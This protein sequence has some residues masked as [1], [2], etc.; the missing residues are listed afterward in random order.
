VGVGTER[1]RGYAITVV[2]AALAGVVF[3]EVART[4]N[5]FEQPTV[6]LTIVGGAAVVAVLWLAI[7]RLDWAVALGFLLLSVVRFEPAPTDIVLGI[8]VAVA[9]VTSRVALE[10]VPP[11]IFALAGAYLVLNIVSTVEAVDPIRALVFFSITAYLLALAV[12]V[13]NYVRSEGTVKLIVRCY[14]WGAAIV[15]IPTLAALFV[16]FPGGDFLLYDGTR[17]QG[18]FK[19]P[20]VFGPFLVPAVLILLE[21]I[22]HPHVVTRRR[23]VA[24]ILALLLTCG[25]VFAYSRAGWLNI[26]LGV[27]TMLAVLTFRRGGGGRAL[28]LLLAIL[29]GVSAATTVL[30]VSGSSSFFDERA[31]LHEYDS[32]RFSA[33][34]SG[35]EIASSHPFGIGPGQ[36]ERFSETGAHS[37]YVRTLAEQ[38]LLGA[39]AMIGLMFATL[40]LAARNAI[41]GRSAYGVGSA[42]LLAA[43]VGI[44]ANSAF[45]DTLHWRHLWLVA[46]LIW[47]GAARRAWN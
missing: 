23:F 42:A 8:A 33:Q 1:L 27:L 46:A 40:V 2:F 5:E 17:A 11:A 45:V 43:W 13:T 37:L 6:G 30:I 26:S 20:N 29:I 15:T 12:W 38:G 28:A 14:V 22:L 7:V 3:A 34:A 19:D 4:L 9:V 10:Q 24:A 47:V 31:R 16:T 18:L 35:L 44:L 25:V 21:D 36:F 41:E 32:D 39:A